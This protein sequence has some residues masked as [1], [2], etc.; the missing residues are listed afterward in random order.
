MLSSAAHQPKSKVKPAV[1]TRAE[2]P[3]LGVRSGKNYIEANAV[4]AIM[5]GAPLLRDARHPPVGIDASRP[6][7][8]AR[9]AAA[10]PRRPEPMRYTQKPDYGKVPGYLEHVRREIEEEKA[11]I[12][13]E[14][15]ARDEDEASK[16]VQPLPESEQQA[17]LR[18]LKAKWDEV[19]RKYQLMTHTTK[20]DTL[21]KLHRCA[22]PPLPQ[23]CCARL[24]AE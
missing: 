14:V 12:R 22:S 15:L 6:S 7:P 9:N 8:V 19:N 24:A 10:P 21:S 18:A 11:L 3:V 13:E 17:L 16:R 4:E 2:K 5:S 20:L 1:P 23:S